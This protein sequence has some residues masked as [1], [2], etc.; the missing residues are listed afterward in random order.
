MCGIVGY[1]GGGNASDILL[2]GLKKLEYRGYDS[3]G[4]VVFKNGGLE[5]R[6]SVG[7][8]AELEKALLREPLAG[9]AG[10]GHTRWATHGRP[11]E[12]N[13]HP[14][15]DCTGRVVV[16][17]NGIVENYRA[18]KADLA[19]RGHAF[20]SQTDTEVLAH[21]IE[22]A[23]AP[24]SKKG[25]VAPEVFARKVRQALAGVKG[26]YALGIVSADCPGVVIGARK[27]CPLAVGV[28][29]GETFLT[30][31][32][33]AILA[34][35]RRAVFLEDGEMALL[36]PAG[37]RVERLDTGDP[38]AKTV[39]TVTWDALQAEKGGYRHF[40][41]KEIHEQA[42]AVEDTLRGKLDLDDWR[43]HLDTLHLTPDQIKNF[44]RL[45]IVACGTSWHAGLV[46]KY[47]VEK[48]IGAPCEVE[49]ASEFRYREPA[50]DARDLVLT[51]SQ[52]GETADTIAALRYAKAKG[53]R[54]LSICNAVGSTLYRE[55]HGK[56][57][58]HC[59]PEIGVA[60]TKAFVAQLTVLILLA[61]YG[62]L[63]RETLTRGEVEPIFKDLLHLPRW[64]TEAV[65][66]EKKII[67][68]AKKFHQ[69]RDFLFLGR[70]LNYPIALEGALKLKEISYIHAE[71]YPAG[72]LKHG[73]IALIDDNVPVVAI[74]TQSSVYEKM[75]S[76]VEEVKARGGAV[77]LVATAGDARARAITEDVIFLPPVPEVLAPCVTVV[78][79][80]LLSYH[81]AVLRGCDVDQPRN[82]AKSVTV[83]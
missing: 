17:H 76:N 8:L 52:S 38:V 33:L 12:E 54:T 39:T 34:R 83:E 14:H 27:E 79:L 15:R 74:A 4:M 72:E 59:G 55:A 78:P 40:M 5:I 23:L 50:L 58:T 65:A 57:L 6:R 49:I 35:T 45:L 31:D 77:I 75:I 37:W 13:A 66:L 82:L 48:W 80:Q 62:A 3:A 24:E 32:V 67:P 20:A 43:V 51:I 64:I 63:A 70:H 36:S 19:A 22:D 47:L 42:R 71:G 30:S 46:G 28:G 2:E 26:A 29:E 41:L 44:R 1:T 11:S 69:K 7:K 25:P 53:A 10:I 9:T 81:I 73:P 18:L 56:I 21:L 16:V 68:M 61:L 60:S